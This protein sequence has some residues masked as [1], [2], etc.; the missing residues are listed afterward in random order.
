MV[1][2]ALCR[3]V[4]LW[5]NLMLWLLY[6]AM[7]MGGGYVGMASTI[8]LGQTRDEECEGKHLFAERF[9]MGKITQ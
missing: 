7:C 4:A 5:V 3:N 6:I 1:K 2:R 8:V 9:Q